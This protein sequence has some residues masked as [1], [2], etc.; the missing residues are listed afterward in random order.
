MPSSRSGS[1][2]V[3]G[4]RR[5]AQSSGPVAQSQVRLIGGEYRS[6][7]LAFAPA[8][9]LR[10][11]HDR[12]RETAF[13]W[14]CARSGSGRWGL[15]GL[16]C[17]D[18]FAGSGVMGAEA[19]SR[20]AA[21][22]T[23]VDINAA[24][25]HQIHGE[26][27]RLTSPAADRASQQAVS[28]ADQNSADG[29]RFAVLKSDAISALDS[30]AQRAPASTF[31]IVFL[32]PPFDSGLITPVLLKLASSGLLSQNA[33]IYFEAEASL[34]MTAAEPVGWQ[35]LKHKTSSQLQYGLLHA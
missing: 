15:A 14:L 9:G 19:L 25:C 4:G 35:R 28:N 27:T 22:V 11:T 17:L 29:P 31:D 5:T 33:L 13:N 7:K 23:L 12:I 26:L 10:P 18:L 3:R 16:H 20:G 2:S 6:R 8:E 24:V 1:Q 34:D 32:D 21:S 30:L